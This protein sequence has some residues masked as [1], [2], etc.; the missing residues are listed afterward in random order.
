MPQEKEI[1]RRNN[2]IC[3]EFQRLRNADFTVDETLKIIK[4]RL[5]HRKFDCNKKLRI[6]TIYNI[7]YGH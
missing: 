7:V 1:Q 3:Q 4:K 2:W 6:R 5:R